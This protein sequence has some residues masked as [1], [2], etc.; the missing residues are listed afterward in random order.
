MV[1]LAPAKTPPAGVKWLESAT[2]KI[3]ATPEMKDKLFQSAFWFEP[4]A[5]TRLGR[6]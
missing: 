1:L 3:L 5:R 6:A 2:L 4:K